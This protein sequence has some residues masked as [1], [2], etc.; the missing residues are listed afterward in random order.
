VESG[1]TYSVLDVTDVPNEP[2][3]AMKVRSRPDRS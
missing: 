2:T 3:E 1:V